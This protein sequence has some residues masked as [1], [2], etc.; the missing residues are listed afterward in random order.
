MSMMDPRL[1]NG[2]KTEEK[3]NKTVRNAGSGK[4]PAANSAYK[5]RIYPYDDQA[6]LIA[7]T[8]GCC[9]LFWNLRLEDVC[10]AWTEYKINI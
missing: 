7:K 4:R 9:R 3:K 8:F 2:G 6:I 1:K 10:W 5:Y